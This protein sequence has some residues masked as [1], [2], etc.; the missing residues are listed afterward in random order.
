[1][2]QKTIGKKAFERQKNSS[3]FAMIAK[4]SEYGIGFSR[5]RYIGKYNGKWTV[6]SEMEETD[7]RKTWTRYFKEV[8]AGIGEFSKYYDDFTFSDD[9]LELLTD[10]ERIERAKYVEKNRVEVD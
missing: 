2:E 8:F 3:K 5:T 6:F 9:E 7:Q 10:D 1:M 4:R